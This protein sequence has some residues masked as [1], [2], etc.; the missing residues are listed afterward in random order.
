MR[1]CRYGWSR[2]TIPTWTLAKF[3]PARRLPCRGSR[4]SIVSDTARM[5]VVGQRCASVA[6]GHEIHD[7]IIRR[8]NVKLQLL[9]RR[10]LLEHLHR[11]LEVGCLAPGCDGLVGAS[12]QLR[13]IDG[14]QH[15]RAVI[16]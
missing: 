4:P 11:Q 10:H 5:Q 7:G 14:R 12:A 1:T 9:A 13:R 6:R 3:D 2:N 15:A 8:T 16:E